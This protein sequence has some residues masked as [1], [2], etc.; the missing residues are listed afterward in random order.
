VLG[1]KPEPLSHANGL[2]IKAW[3][4]L[5]NGMGGLDWAGLPL[6]VDL[7]GIEDIEALV[8]ALLVIKTHRPP[9]AGAPPEPDGTD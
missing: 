8:D 6:V 5:A 4:L 7:L 2:A 1:P 3:N 9:D